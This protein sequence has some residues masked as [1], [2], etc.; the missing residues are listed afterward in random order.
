MLLCGPVQRSANGASFNPSRRERER[1][2][3][4]DTYHEFL[5]ARRQADEQGG[6]EPIALSDKLFPFQRYLTE[7]AIR[8]GRAAIFADCGLGKSLCE[9]CWAD[10]VVRKTNKP[11]LILT[12]LAVSYQMV[13]EAAKFGYECKRSSEG[14]FTSK[15]V[16][17]NYQRLHY[18][19]P[20]DFAGVV[21]DESSVLKNFEA[22]T[23]AAVTEFMRKTPYRL[24]ATATA[25]PN[26]FFELGTSSEALGYLGYSDMLS[27]FF[28]QETKKDYLGWGRSSYR[29]RGHAEIPFWRWVCSWARVCRKPSDMGFE[30][31]GFNLPPLNVQQHILE[32]STPRSGC[33]FSTPAKT[34]AEQREERRVTIRERCE[35][36]AEYADRNN[37]CVV[38]CHLND[39]ADLVEKLIPDAKQVSG[40]MADELKEERLMA[41]ADGQIKTLVT[42]PKIASHGLNWQHC[43]TTA[44]FTSHSFENYYQ[45]IR[46]FWRFGQ[47]HPVDVLVIASNG[48]RRVIANLDRKAAQADKMFDAL[49]EYANRELRID[50]RSEF[51]KQERIPSWL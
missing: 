2:R 18:F 15:I 24:L 28:K 49:C 1:K 37:F 19:N 22:R 8:K 33:L 45:S 38:W 50:R 12:P 11:V 4:V 23:K 51:Q 42:K 44:T 29:F 46:R 40:S 47:E 26:D 21:C 27:Q 13:R 7:W 5:N 41:F 17:T 35:A 36:A 20:D 3:A 10:N 34:L 30:D 48:E 43:H 6:F 39:E 32:D 16:T 31:D 25:A 14:K 9:L